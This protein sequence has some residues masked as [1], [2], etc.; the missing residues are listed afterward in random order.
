VSL[1]DE[2]DLKKIRTRKSTN[3]AKYLYGGCDSAD[4]LRALDW[5]DKYKP[6]FS[7]PIR[8]AELDAAYAQGM[9]RKEQLRDG[10]YYWGV[11]RNARVARWSAKHQLFFHQ[12]KKFEHWF[13]ESIPHPVDEKTNFMFGKV[14]G[15]DVFAPWVE[16]EPLDFE[17]VADAQ[18][19][20]SKL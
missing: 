12:R 4:D 18:E 7:V 11:C 14:V 1:I 8:P 16:V 5:Q 3:E 20:A 17:R 9:L 19:F 15:F 10:E 13:V 2:S 6:K